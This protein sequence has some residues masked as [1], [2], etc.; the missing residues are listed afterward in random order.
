ME[1]VFFFLSSRGICQENKKVQEMSDS[2]QNCKFQSQIVMI[3]AT[4]FHAK[5]I[6]PHI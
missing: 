4:I 5:Q 1:N 2:C 3:M 6:G